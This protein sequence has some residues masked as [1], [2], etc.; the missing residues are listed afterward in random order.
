VKVFTQMFSNQ[1]KFFSYQ[2]LFIAFIASFF[3]PCSQVAY[4]RCNQAVE[5]IEKP[6]VTEEVIHGKTFVVSK[7]L[8]KA[9]P[10]AV[11]Q[12]LSDYN[13]AAHVFPILKECELL[14]D[15]GTTKITRHVIAPT[16]IPGTFEYVLEIHETAPNSM[17]WH[18]VSG[19]FHD[20]DGYWK[21]EPMDFGHRTL[22]TYAS[23]VNGGLLMPQ[24]LIRRQFH[25]DMPNALIAL[26]NR[27]ELDQRLAVHHGEQQRSPAE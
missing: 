8:I 5:Q 26:R 24:V 12:V 13:H 27:A 11:W 20:V 18:R 23:Y 19:D 1:L 4:S 10:E 22:V 25:I 14:E 2:I 3:I 7:L 16:G 9:R 21:L 15:K 17:E 6:T